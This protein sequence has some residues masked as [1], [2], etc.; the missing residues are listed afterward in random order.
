M[1]VQIK[2]LA[3]RSFK[4]FARADLPLA[5]LTVLIGA[6]ASGK[7]NAIEAMQLLSW[8]AGGRRLS[9]LLFA[10]K[11]AQ[12]SLRGSLRDFPH[13]GSTIELGCSLE[14]E[15]PFGGIELRSKLELDESGLRVRG[16]CLQSDQPESGHPL[17]EVVESAG[18]RHGNGLEVAY[19]NF[20]RG[21][22]PRISCSDQQAV[23]TQLMTPARFGA[24]HK[25]SQQVIPVAVSRVAEALSSILFLDPQPSQ[26][27]GYS[28]VQETRLQGDGRTV[29]SVLYHIC[30]RPGGKARLLGFIQSLP[31]Q[32]IADVSFLETP[33][34]EVMIKLDETFGGKRVARDAAVLSDG[35]LRVMAVAAA[36]LSVVKGSTVVI[37]EIDNGVHPSRA[38]S[39]LENILKLARERELKVLLTTHN[40]ALLD[41]LPAA[42]IP[43]IVACYRDPASGESRLIRFEDLAH[44][45]EMIAQGPVGRL[46][47]KGIVDRYLKAGQTDEA[48]TDRGLAWISELRKTS[49]GS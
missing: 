39:L 21:R 37:E 41:A 1:L 30:R 35:T 10:M 46:V 22:K 2:S 7:S 43:D 25:Q 13:A 5:P 6:N 40:P 47:T 34:N 19:N 4:S 44:Y 31:E 23:F 24:N 12:L 17:Y 45:P 3:I 36:L 49:V 33:R 18:R 26:M 27:R 29:S 38:G 9:D 48:R 14:A 15:D 32:D 8:L 16:E 42:V 11:E 20:S 28:F